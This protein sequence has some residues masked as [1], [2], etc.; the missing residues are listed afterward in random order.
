MLL[1]LDAQ[2]RS[3]WNREL[4]DDGVCALARARNGERGPLLLQAELAC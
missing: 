3:R 4:I 1:T 2:D